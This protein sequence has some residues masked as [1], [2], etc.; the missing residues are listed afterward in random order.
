MSSER[1]KDMP[2]AVAIF[3]VVLWTEIARD[4]FQNAPQRAGD[5]EASSAFF[6][7]SATT[8]AKFFAPDTRKIAN[9][10][11]ILQNLFNASPCA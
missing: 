3:G 9:K 7:F 11:L 1:F 6:R 2:L 8:P 4:H 5:F 10:F